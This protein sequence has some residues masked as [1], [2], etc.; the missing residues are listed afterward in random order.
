LDNTTR[1]IH[2]SVGSHVC[3]ADPNRI[4]ND[5]ALAR[6]WPTWNRGACATDPVKTAA[7][8]QVADFRDQQLW[9]AIRRGMGVPG[10]LA[11]EMAE[12]VCREGAPVAAF[13]NNDASSSIDILSYCPGGS[14]PAG[15]GSS[16]GREA[17]AGATDTSVPGNPHIEPAEDKDDFFLVTRR[18]DFD[19]LVA[20]HR[21][22]VLQ[23]PSVRD[24][25]SLSVR[26]A[27]GR[28]ANVEAQLG[29]PA[30]RNEAM[31]EQAITQ[32][33]AACRPPG[34][35]GSP[36]GGAPVQRRPI[37]VQRQPEPG[38]AAPEGVEQPGRL[39]AVLRWLG[40]LYDEIVRVLQQLG[41]M[42]EPMPREAPPPRGLPAGCRTFADQAELDAAKVRISSGVLARMP[43]RDVIS[44]I[45]GLA[46]PPASVTREAE[47]QRD[48]ML[49]AI[50]IAARRP[51]SPLRL[52]SGPPTR[53][54]RRDFAQQRA[55]WQRKFDFLDRAHGGRPFDKVSD[56]ARARC[57]P[58]VGSATRWDPDNPD[59]RTCWLS[60]LTA[61]ERQQEILGASSAPGISRHH[62]GTDFDLFD[63]DMN[64][65]EW[66]AG[67][68]FAD[69]YSWMMRNASTYGFIQ[70][71]T[72]TSTFMTAGYIEERWHW[73]YYPAA[74]ALLEFARTHQADVEARLVAEWG[75][76]PEFSHIR[77]Q[78]R[79]FMFN[80][81]ERGR[82]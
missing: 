75:A 12:G 9:P 50:R 1:H 64:P 56:R 34:S 41:T 81:N 78:W 8:R 21:N 82:F 23:S 32:L 17:R 49:A 11:E 40:H 61:D 4:F 59:H 25:G 73:S 62:W 37:P 53:S 20:Q 27:F 22:V 2:V 47:S 43:E 39:A 55:I 63:P 54:G 60:T 77:T 6:L 7:I 16:A 71:F 46:A 65:S 72:A 51:G 28:Y 3:E 33:G 57:G 36:G 70:S 80:V 14:G 24:D 30:T 52:S 68:A 76:A 18:A 79:N 69:E 74:Q 67:G 15:C 31:G 13:H 66:E 19:A 5:A 44:W 29:G 10:T 58:L 45:V 38:T 48:C 26:F 35:G 42:P